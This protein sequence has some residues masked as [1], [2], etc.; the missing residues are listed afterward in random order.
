MGCWRAYDERSKQRE[1][2]GLTTVSHC[3]YPSTE[4]R[5]VDK[6]T[7]AV[8]AT[9]VMVLRL[10]AKRVVEVEGRQTLR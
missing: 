5:I 1:G 3:G 2:G 8:E 6:G 4:V 7:V 9:L 10:G